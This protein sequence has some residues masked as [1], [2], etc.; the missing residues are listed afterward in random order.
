MIEKT[1]FVS[2]VWADAET[3]SDTFRERSGAPSR[4][5]AAKFQTMLDESLVAMSR[6][7]RPPST[8]ASIV[9]VPVAPVHWMVVVAV[10][11]P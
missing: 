8:D 7:F 9:T 3:R 10:A 6:Q 4:V 5:A 2:S 11:E 1:P